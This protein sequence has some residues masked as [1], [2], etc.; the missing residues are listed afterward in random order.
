MITFPHY[1]QVPEVFQGR[2]IINGSPVDVFVPCRCDILFK[3][4]G[5]LLEFWN[6]DDNDEDDDDDGATLLFF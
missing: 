5:A 3:I 4:Q 2:D 6:D 1:D